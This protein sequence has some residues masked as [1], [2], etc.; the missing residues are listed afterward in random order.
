[1]PSLTN[2]NRLLPVLSLIHRRLLSGC[3]FLWLLN[4]I[5]KAC[6]HVGRAHQFYFDWT[7][8]IPTFAIAASI[9]L[10][11]CLAI[12]FCH[13][14]R[15]L[16]ALEDSWAILLKR[17][18]MLYGLR[19]SYLAASCITLFWFSLFFATAS[20]D[21]SAKALACLMSDIGQY[22]LAERIYLCSPDLNQNKASGRYNSIASW[23]RSSNTH[24]DPV[25]MWRKND[26]VAKVYGSESLEMAG[27][28]FYIGLTC[29]S[30]MVN[31]DAEAIYWHS[32]A[33]K[34]YE[35]N[36]CVTK[37]VDAL[38]Q[39]AIMQNET[40][41]PEC[42][43][44][45]L[46]AASLMPSLDEA[47]FVCTNIIEYL[48]KSNGDDAQAVMFHRAF[49]NSPEEAQHTTPF[50][51]P[52][53]PEF[54]ILALAIFGSGLGCSIGKWQAIQFLTLEYSQRCKEERSD[55]HIFLNSL[56][57]IITLNLIQHNQEIAEQNSRLLLSVAEG[58]Q[59]NSFH[60]AAC[61]NAALF[62]NSALRFELMR[63]L[64][65]VALAG[66]FWL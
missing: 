37:C 42:K 2:A 6:E 16:F 40:N 34:L 39:M 17:K 56:D 4:W 47:P 64:F 7:V 36:H 25:T 32:K 27:R 46:K 8:A 1:M 51:S 13:K 38:A 5:C 58:N 11:N 28:F 33:F 61:D 29:E 50:S 24:E 60:L 53:A 22:E 9:A 20:F 57:E 66:S 35:K 23:H 55:S 65:A 52:F 14:E 41:K 59:A 15:E 45:L 12:L 31:R 10:L 3:L 48:A 62:R 43:R 49:K 54:Y 18:K 30:G 26:A 21:C 63:G 19:I 44:L